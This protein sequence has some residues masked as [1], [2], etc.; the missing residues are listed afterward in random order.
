MLNSMINLFKEE[1]I[2]RTGIFILSCLVAW[3]LIAGL[4][5]LNLFL[6]IQFNWSFDTILFIILLIA[7][8]IS[9]GL[10]KKESV[11]DANMKEKDLIFSGIIYFACILS[12]IAFSA[13][14]LYI[15]NVHLI[16]QDFWVI[17]L[18]TNF[19]WLCSSFVILFFAK[20]SSKINDDRQPIESKC[21]EL[22]AENSDIRRRLADINNLAVAYEEEGPFDDPQEAFDRVRKIADLSSLEE[23]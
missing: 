13:T 1:N 18:F 6:M 23:K 20:E 17:A 10:S 21:P 22:L 2:K 15:T 5:C 9:L 8:I 4:L 11:I 12:E 16:R 14:I 19:I 3:P 7:I